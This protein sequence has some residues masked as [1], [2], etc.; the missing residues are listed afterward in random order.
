MAEKEL[1]HSLVYDNNT[2]TVRG[3]TQV[4]EIS[5]KEA[6]F[7]LSHNTLFVK[8]GGLNVTK[9]D[10][11]QGVVVLEVASLTSLTYRQSGISFKGLFR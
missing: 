6:Q 11:E 10:K 5:E 1:Q 2:L 8:G 3:V 7:K 4:V 9:L